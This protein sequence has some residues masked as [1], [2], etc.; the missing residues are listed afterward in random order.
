MILKKRGM[1]RDVGLVCKI[2]VIAMTIALVGDIMSTCWVGWCL[3]HGLAHAN[4]LRLWELDREK[5]ESA[6][7][8]VSTRL[9]FQRQNVY[10]LLYLLVASSANN[11][12]MVYYLNSPRFSVW[13]ALGTSLLSVCAVSGLHLIFSW[14]GVLV[15]APALSYVITICIF[16]LVLP[17]E[18][19]LRRVLVVHLV[20]FAAGYVLLQLL[21]R[22]PFDS[23]MF[24]IIWFV[25]IM[26]LFR[27]IMRFVVTRQ[28]W[29][30]SWDSRIFNSDDLSR[31]CNRQNAWVFL[32]W[33]QVTMAVYFRLAVT[34]LDSKALS[35][36]IVM[37]QSFLEIV[38]RLTHQSRDAWL[39]NLS[40]RRIRRVS[41]K[42]V[43]SD[44]NAMSSYCR[45]E[46]NEPPTKRPEAK[47][48]FYAL[49]IL[50]EMMAE[51]VG[52]VVSIFQIW[53]WKRAPLVSPY[54]WFATQRLNEPIDV[55]RL[56]WFACLQF[57]CEVAVDT[58]CIKFEKYDTSSVKI[59]WHLFFLPCF[60]GSLAAQILVLHGDSYD[61]CRDGLDFCYCVNN[62]L[63]KHGVRETYCK[64]IYPHVDF[65]L[66]NFTLT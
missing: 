5:K 4:A 24:F 54:P 28:V 8:R 55:S 57:A 25:V 38:L 13:R 49:V 6:K 46:K 20:V 50:S 26:P 64:L 44:V 62:G 51:Y 39:T 31:Q 30:L 45:D 61:V 2:A 32:A 17:L 60:L 47:N 27:E 58:V 22:L 52:I 40:K 11:F 3:N 23:A 48:R 29:Y 42:L 35:W 16:R 14:D 18:R 9:D 53:Y 63:V 65:S 1:L 59:R 41:T 33:Y 66:S 34:N 36:V 37:C 43:L 15:L 19:T 56:F 12:F 21:W 10:S 7:L